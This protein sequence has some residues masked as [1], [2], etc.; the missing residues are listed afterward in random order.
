MTIKT[1]YTGDFH[2][3]C[4]HLQSGTILHTDAPTDNNG[5]GETFSPTDL[6][7]TAAGTCM[8]TFM[9][10]QARKDKVELDGSEI[11]ITK[12]MTQSPPRK[13]E[14]LVM[15]LTMKTSIPITDI[16]KANYEEF[17]VNCPVMLSLHSE[18]IKEVRFQ[19]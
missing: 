3:E 16:Q 15:S 9:A 7:A 12:I 19:W 14:K 18:L 4:T 13:I 6:L 8:I 10:I 2:T 11:E 17:A 5:K 1:I